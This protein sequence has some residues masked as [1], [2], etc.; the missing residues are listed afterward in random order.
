MVGNC[1]QLQKYVED[2]VRSRL[3]IANKIM[4]GISSTS[5][6]ITSRLPETDTKYVTVHNV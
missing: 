1:P 3:D 5:K 4:D 2:S 6:L